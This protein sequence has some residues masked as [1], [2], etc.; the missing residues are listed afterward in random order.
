M[1]GKKEL[2][3]LLFTVMLCFTYI[4]LA[5][6][7]IGNPEKPANRDAGRVVDLEKVLEISDTGVG[8]YMES[9]ML[10]KVAP[11]QSIF[12]LDREQLLRFD[13]SG[14]F[15]RNYFKRGQ[16]PGELELVSNY[17]L[18]NDHIIIHN[19]RPNKIV[20]LNLEGELVKEFRVEQPGAGFMILIAHIDGMFYLHRNEGIPVVKGQPR[21][22]DFPKMIVAVSDEGKSV[23]DLQPF[24][25]K[26]FVAVQGGSRGS[27]D[28]NSLIAAQYNKKYLF[29]SHT[30]EYQVKLFDLENNRVL[31][32]FNRRYK[33]I[34]TPE[35][36]K[37]SNRG[38]LV[39][40]NQKFTAPDLEHISDI[41][42]L[43]VV[44]DQLWVMTSTL[45][46]K[47]GWLVDVYDAQGRYLDNFYLK[48]PK[49]LSYRDTQTMGFRMVIDPPG[50][51]L[52][53]LRSN[54]E[55]LMELVKYRLS[56]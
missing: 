26:R 10:P 51:F 3:F 21:I 2:L 28:I 48:F 42:H 47:R 23:K 50:D 38:Y 37:N 17:L 52:Y 11:D 54:E 7:I 36:I 14:N 49:P 18:T 16:G 41:C 6:E 9:P 53:R 12:V 1:R 4:L 55:G 22:I 31:R 27:I 5:Q 20:Y 40:N 29:I 56:R 19:A 15:L 46:K 13:R 45:D 24:P 8:Y 32:T 43:E 34:K 35:E 25:I 44:K 33:R 39:L 30:P